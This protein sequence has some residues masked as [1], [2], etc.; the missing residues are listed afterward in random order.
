MTAIRFF[1][2]RVVLPI[3]VMAVIWGA[4]SAILALP[5]IVGML[6]GLLVG[7]IFGNIVSVRAVEVWY[8]RK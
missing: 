5:P 2:L 3:L 7:G 4:I 8:S 1:G 6:G